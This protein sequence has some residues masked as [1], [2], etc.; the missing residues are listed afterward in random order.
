M[1][2]LDIF[3]CVLGT[4]DVWLQIIT[5][6][7]SYRHEGFACNTF[8]IFSQL[9]IEDVFFFFEFAVKFTLSL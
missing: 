4:V 2:N 9:W 5:V 8:F 1:I 7:V 6:F 3:I